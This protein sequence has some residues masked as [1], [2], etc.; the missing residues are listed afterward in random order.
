FF[1]TT[2]EADRKIVVFPLPVHVNGEREVLA[3]LEKIDLLL[4]KKC[5]SAEIDVF[6]AR[7]KAFDD[8][9]DLWMKQGLATR[10][11]DRGRATF[12][13]RPEAFFGRE[14]HLQNVGRVLN[15]AAS[16]A[17][18]VAAKQRLEHEH[19]RILLAPFQ[20]LSEDVSGYRPG[21]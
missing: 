7:D 20:L 2:L 16:R 5:V 14:L 4:E 17:R 19:K 1:V 9:G 15:F 3:G 13:G 12:I 8:F 18:Q 10:D 21:L 11:R 6:L